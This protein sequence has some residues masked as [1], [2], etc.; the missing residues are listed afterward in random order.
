MFGLL[1]THPHSSLSVVSAFSILTFSRR[2]SKPR[3]SLVSILFRS[4]PL[5]ARP[6][7]LYQPRY[8]DTDFSCVLDPP[9]YAISIICLVYL[10]DCSESERHILPQ[11]VGTYSPSWPPIPYIHT[12][13]TLSRSPSSSSPVLHVGDSDTMPTSS[14]YSTFPTMLGLLLFSLPVDFASPLL[15]R[16]LPL[17][18]FLHWS[19]AML[20]MIAASAKMCPG[21]AQHDHKNTLSNSGESANPRRRF[22]STLIISEHSP[23]P[24]RTRTPMPPWDFR[25]SLS[26]L[27]GTP[28]RAT[29]R[30]AHKNVRPTEVHA[31]V[32]PIKRTRYMQRGVLPRQFLQAS[33]HEHHVDRRAGI[34]SHITPTGRERPPPP[35]YYQSPLVPATG[36]GN[37]A[38]EEGQ[39][40]TLASRQNPLRL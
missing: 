13:H 16:L 25:M 3:W 38:N 7:S 20:P 29:C 35:N 10:A 4:I 17:R 12:P 30:E 31:L 8:I 9:K 37:T 14:V 36:E 2:R 23:P 32:S 22:V 21:H 6:G 5:E 26:A 15:V 33:Y 39:G 18:I 19:P 24:S 40:Q 28:K 34:Y 11:L 27:G 1:I